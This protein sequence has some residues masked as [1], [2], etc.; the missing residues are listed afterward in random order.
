M[1]IDCE[2]LPTKKYRIVGPHCCPTMEKFL[3]N[4]SVFQFKFGTIQIG[5][6]GP[7]PLYFALMYCPFCGEKITSSET[8]T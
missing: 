7:N 3:R 6:G 2:I 5:N 8:Y 4:G 1:Q